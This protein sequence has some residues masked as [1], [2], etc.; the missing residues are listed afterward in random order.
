MASQD[1]IFK[2]V[3]ECVAKVVDAEPAGI[4]AGD[5]IIADLGADSLDLLDLIFQLEQRFDIRIK[6]RDIERRAQVELGGAPMEIGGIYT[7]QAL[8]QLRRVLPEVPPEELHD[9]L[10]PSRLAYSFRVQT[11]VNLVAR[12]LPEQHPLG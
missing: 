4:K 10:M 7:P 8:A 5:R 1:E 12:L 2:G 9:K 3:V 11:F 6:P